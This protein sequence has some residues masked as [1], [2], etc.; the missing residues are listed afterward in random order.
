MPPDTIVRLLELAFLAKVQNR[1][2]EEAQCGQGQH[3][4][5]QTVE[6]A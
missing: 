6:E 4:R 3:S 5:L 2:H 1:K